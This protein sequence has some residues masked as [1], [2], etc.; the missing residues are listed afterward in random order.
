MSLSPQYRTIS[1]LSNIFQ[2]NQFNLYIMGTKN[3]NKK[4]PWNRLDNFS[5]YRTGHHDGIKQFSSLE[6]C[7]HV[8]SQKIIDFFSNLSCKKI[9]D[10]ALEFLLGISAAGGDICIS[11]RLLRI[12]LLSLASTMHRFFLIQSFSTFLILRT[13]NTVPHIAVTPNHKMIFIAA[14]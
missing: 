3:W 13:F 9:Q 4:I 6:M 7:L 14:S 11:G 2:R 12:V 8:Y 5:N 1:T 10:A